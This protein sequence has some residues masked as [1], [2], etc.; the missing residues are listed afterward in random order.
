M[1]TLLPLAESDA[2][3]LDVARQA[4]C[5]ECQREIRQEYRPEVATH[6]PNWSRLVAARSDS[7][8]LLAQARIPN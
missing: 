4:I 1:P 5:L 7:M 6:R 2:E 3:V 8:E